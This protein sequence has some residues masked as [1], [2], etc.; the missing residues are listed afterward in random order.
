MQ[1]SPNNI[2]YSQTV[3]NTDVGP[4]KV[5]GSWPAELSQQMNDWSFQCMEC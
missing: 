2:E 5:M 3:L 1:L 4:V